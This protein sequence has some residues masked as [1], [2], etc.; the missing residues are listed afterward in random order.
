MCHLFGYIEGRRH[1]VDTTFFYTHQKR[2][3]EPTKRISMTELQLDKAHMIILAMLWALS[4]LGWRLIPRE[5]PPLKKALK[6]IAISLTALP[7]SIL[8]AALLEI[9]ACYHW[10][11]THHLWSNDQA[12]AQPPTATPERKGNHGK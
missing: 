9:F 11:E 8:V 3:G 4:L 5:T 1:R 12:Q 7:L 2:N 10:D 6:R